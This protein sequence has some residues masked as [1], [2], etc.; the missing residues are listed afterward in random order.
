MA[1]P[2]T[3]HIFVSLAAPTLS[4]MEALAVRVAGAPV[5]YEL[6]LDYLQD[7]TQFESQLHQMLM[8]L[9]SPADHRHVSDGARGRHVAGHAR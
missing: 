6:R 2:T 7:F 4:A 8:R 9:H 1:K 3:P 5:G